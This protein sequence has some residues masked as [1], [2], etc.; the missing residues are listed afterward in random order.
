MPRYRINMYNVA[1]E[2]NKKKRQQS[3]NEAFADPFILDH[4]LETKIRTSFDAEVQVD[5]EN[6]RRALRSTGDLLRSKDIHVG[7]KDWTGWYSADVIR[8]AR[9][10]LDAEYTP[11]EIAD[12]E[13]ILT[14]P[15]PE[16]TII[17]VDGEELT[18]FEDSVVR[19]FIKQLRKRH[20][21]LVRYQLAIQFAEANPKM[22]FSSPRGGAQ[23]GGIS[24]LRTINGIG[25][26]FSAVRNQLHV[27]GGVTNIDEWMDAGDSHHFQALLAHAG[28]VQEAQRSGNPAILH[29]IENETPEPPSPEMIA[30]TAELHAEEA[31]ASI[32]REQAMQAYEEANQ[33]FHEHMEGRSTSTP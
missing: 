30:W 5:A 23:G 7:F 15:L 4:K 14:T 9:R 26:T 2:D 31:E 8:C 24:M 17:S 1:W 22:E 20:R 16:T 19:P 6:L 11:E 10:K 13:S 3:F 18:I 28:E 25:I 21:T 29:A 27:K 12:P 33:A 32:P